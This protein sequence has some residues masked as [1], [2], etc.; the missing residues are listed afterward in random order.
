MAILWLSLLIGAVSM[1]YAS[2]GQAG[3]SGYLGA[4]ALLG[5]SQR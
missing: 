5:V 3:G 4:M 1:L 2:V